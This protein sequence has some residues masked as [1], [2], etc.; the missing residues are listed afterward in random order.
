MAL[1]GKNN[2]S[3]LDAFLERESYEK[4]M[5]EKQE[6]DQS[7]AFIDLRKKALY[8]KVNLDNQLIIPRQSS[9]ISL[10]GKVRTFDFVADA[11]RQLR[12]NLNARAEAGTFRE[13]GAYFE[14]NITPR[15]NSWADAYRAY[16][17][18]LSRG[19]IDNRLDTRQKKAEIKTIRQFVPIF[20]DFVANLGPTIPVTFMSYW[21]SRRASIFQTGLAIDLNNE[22]Y[23]DDEVSIEKYHEDRNY[24]IFTR[25]AQNHGFILDRH[26][27]Q[28][29]VVN[30]TS[31]KM[32]ELLKLAGHIN[33][34][35]FFDNA[36]YTPYEE[37]F[38]EMV[39]FISDFYAS[40]FS[41]E[42]SYAEICHKNGKT[43]YSLKTRP[44]FN[45]ATI[46]GAV[47]DLGI[48]YWLRVFTF[49]KAREANADMSQQEF[50]N[51]VKKAVNME[52]SL[53]RLAALR[54]INDEFNPLRVEQSDRKPNFVF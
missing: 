52:K 43:S 31:Q 37:E 5:D 10:D 13:S 35:G 4:Y 11:F 7:V 47:S 12:D 28:R 1:S 51:I 34:K 30:F 36:F 29:L 16:L 50:D 39:Q 45:F 21:A 18:T 25:E 2:M 40:E 48:D 41:Q 44:T 53:D 6:Q 17:D 26:A 19:F 46:Q 15:Q 54:Y 33:L 32:Q 24:K 20:L 22:Q 8:G 49:I 27:P 23:G 3:A 14:L 38:N 9:L 42:S